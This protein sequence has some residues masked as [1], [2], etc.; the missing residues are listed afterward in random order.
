A[1]GGINFGDSTANLYRDVAGEIKTDGQLNVNGLQITNGGFLLTNTNTLSFKCTQGS[2]ANTCI[3][4]SDNVNHTWTSGTG[5]EVV[6]IGHY[7]PTSGNGVFNNF[8]LQGTVNQTGGANGITRGLYVNPTLTSAYDFRGLETAGYIATT[9]NT[10]LTQNILFNQP[11]YATT[12]AATLANAINL[13]VSGAP[14]SGPNMTISSSSAL[15]I[16]GGA[17]NGGG[18]VTNAYGLYVNAPTGATNNYAAAFMGGNVGIG[19][20][21]PGYPLYVVSS[22]VSTGVYISNNYSGGNTPIGIQANTGGANGIGVLGLST[23]SSGIGVKGQTNDIAGY[24]V[25]G[26]NTTAGGYAGYFT[27]GATGIYASGGT[28]AGVFNG[29]VGIG[30]TSP[31]GVFVV[32]PAADAVNNVQFVTHSGSNV[33]SID[34]ANSRVGIGNAYTSPSATLD[35]NG[36]VRVGA[37]AGSPHNLLTFN[38]SG[39]NDGQFYS[40]GVSANN[41][42]MLGGSPFVSTAPSSPIMTWALSTGLVGISTSSPNATLAVIGASS[43]LPTLLVQGT[44]SQMTILNVTTSTGTSLL[45]V[46]ANGNVGIGTSNP[47]Y[48]LDVNGSIHL[49]NSFRMDSSYSIIWPGATIRSDGNSTN[50]LIRFFTVGNSSNNEAMRIDSSANVGIGT[51]TPSA[52]LSVTGTSAIDPF[53]I[54]STSGV[55]LMHVNQAGALS[56]NGQY[57]TSGQ[58]LQSNGNASSPT[59]IS[60]STLAS[61]LNAFIQGGNSFGATGTLGTLDNN[62]LQLMASSSP[63]VTILPN[64]NVGIGTANPSYSL[65]VRGNGWINAQNYYAVGS[66]RA[67]GYL[68][69]NLQ[70]GNSSQWTSLSL[71][72]NNSERLRIDNSGNLGIGTTTPTALLSLAASTTAAGGINF[73]D[74]TANLYRSGAGAIK[75]DGNLYVGSNL[76]VGGSQITF[77]GTTNAAIYNNNSNSGANL[78]IVGANNANSYLSLQSTSGVGTS[79]YINFLVGNNGGTEAMRI[80]DS[81]NVG[82]GSTSP[83]SLLTLQ[84]TTTTGSLLTIASSSGSTLLTVLPNGNVGIGTG[85]PSYTLDVTGSAR[86]SSYAWSN[87]SFIAG[88]T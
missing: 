75:T 26:S 71:F 67:L 80:I 12:A 59:W 63:A 85:N 52:R 8:E 87:F 14:I 78:K 9:S 48:A 24:G 37:A 44:S 49:N 81:G 25:Y 16:Q 83:S 61:S 1:A 31:S 18:A 29:N 7:L 64:G 50:G 84:G 62:A 30:T 22:V 35:V 43:S 5:Q 3:S 19:T 36:T 23:G 10:T 45:T 55:S 69:N 57:G 39:I 27:G 72:S 66:S 6:S 2:V 15:T 73:G 21:S 42:L 77:T 4:F 32:Q 33:L 70:L 82:I 53:D 54:S 38:T 28:Y 86:F 58:I 40:D 46:L 20:A 17:V 79:D 76:A 74:S 13:S 88:N 41:I 56:F 68:G 51:S 11:T 60:T 47:G 65:D 34:T